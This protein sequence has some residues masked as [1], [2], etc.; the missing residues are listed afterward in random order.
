[1]VTTYSARRKKFVRVRIV[2]PRH[3]KPRDG[4]AKSALNAAAN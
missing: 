4:G 1:M 2:K 3:K